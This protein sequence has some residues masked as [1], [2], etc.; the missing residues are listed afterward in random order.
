MDGHSGEYAFMTGMF[1]HGIPIDKQGEAQ[2][3]VP[4]QRSAATVLVDL[5]PEEVLITEPQTADNASQ[6]TEMQHQPYI[7]GGPLS[8]QP[9][10]AEGPVL[11]SMQL[12]V[13]HEQ[14]HH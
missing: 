14:S 6:I 7:A 10:F 8:L 11:T 9:A 1:G 2:L 12:L 13:A 4:L 3:V 5:V